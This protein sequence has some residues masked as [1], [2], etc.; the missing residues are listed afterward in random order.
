M[1]VQNPVMGKQVFDLAMAESSTSKKSYNELHS[2]SPILPGNQTLVPLDSNSNFQS[3]KTKKRIEFTRS[4]M[5]RAWGASAIAHQFAVV[6]DLID[7]QQQ[8]Q[9]RREE[10]EAVKLVEEFEKSE[11]LELQALIDSYHTSLTTTR[12][13]GRVRNSVG[14]SRRPQRQLHECYALQTNAT[15]DNDSSRR[16]QS[17]HRGDVRGSAGVEEVH[18][19]CHRGQST[20]TTAQ[21]E[22]CGSTSNGLTDNT[23]FG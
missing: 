10:E 8:E 2:Q 3:P 22:L 12:Q 13:E 17:R 1:S 7:V 23:S 20:T 16:G 9:K 18:V 4:A 11:T 19:R 21:Q 5:G 14:G 6:P 15:R